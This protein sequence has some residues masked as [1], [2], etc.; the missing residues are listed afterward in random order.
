MIIADTTVIIDLWR[1]K[2]NIKK[3]LERK[4]N[5]KLCVSAITIE[6]IYDGL[7]YT[8]EK[9][10][11]ELFEKIKDQYEKIFG[12]FEIIPI[13]IIILKQ[14]GIKKGQLR[15]KGIIMDTADCIIGI[16]AEIIK[17][18]S[19]ITRNPKHFEEFQ[20]EILSYEV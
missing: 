7:G 16:T 12:D 15:S 10:G 9:K 2:K 6:E 19:I 5:E 4:K 1:G 11:L 14:A 18:N 20:T 3:C 13:D 17:V 8:K